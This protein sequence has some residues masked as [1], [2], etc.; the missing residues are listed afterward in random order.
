[1][2]RRMGDWRFGALGAPRGGT[3]GFASRGVTSARRPRLASR[4]PLCAAALALCAGLGGT[5]AGQEH[6]RQPVEFFDGFL[7]TEGINA[8]NYRYSRGNNQ[9]SITPDTSTFFA[10]DY[11]LAYANFNRASDSRYW[12]NVSVRFESRQSDTLANPGQPGM[13]TIFQL[14]WSTALVSFFVSTGDRGVSRVYTTTTATPQLDGR[15]IRWPEHDNWLRLNAVNGNNFDIDLAILAVVPTSVSIQRRAEDGLSESELAGNTYRAGQLI[16]FVVGMS[17]NVTRGREA[18]L[19]GETG[20]RGAGLYFRIGDGE[21]M[22]AWDFDRSSGTTIEFTYR[23]QEGDHGELSLIEEEGDTRFLR[24]SFG[25]TDAGGDPIYGDLGVASNLVSG[26]YRVDTV[27][28]VVEEATV[29]GSKLVLTFS[30]ALHE[31]HVPAASAFRLWRSLGTS[32]S[33]D[34]VA[35]DGRKVT[36]AL[37]EAS[38]VNE[39]WSVRYTPPADDALRD[40]AGNRAAYFRVDVT[41]ERE[42]HHL[43]FAELKSLSP[44][45]AGATT[46]YKASFPGD[47]EV[48]TVEVRHSPLV[49][50]AIAP[51]DADAGTPGHQFRLPERGRAAATLTVTATSEAAG[52]TITYTVE[53]V[54]RFGLSI[55]VP[56]ESGGVLR[57]DE[58]G[59]LPIQIRSDRPG[60]ELH[61]YRARLALLPVAN[62]GANHDHY[63]LSPA[64]GVLDFAVGD[65]QT[66]TVTL[67]AADDAYDNPDRRFDLRLIDPNVVG[68]EQFITSAFGGGTQSVV[69]AD[70]DA[71][72]GVTTTLNDDGSVTLAWPVGEGEGTDF[73]Y[74]FKVDRDTD[75]VGW[76]DPVS[77]DATGGGSATVDPAAAGLCMGER[78]VFE[79]WRPG[80]PPETVYA[81]PRQA[82][83]PVVS[84]TAMQDAYVPYQGSELDLSDSATAKWTLRR[85]GDARLRL[86]HVRLRYR[87]RDAS[88]EDTANAGFFAGDSTRVIKHPPW[89]GDGRVFCAMT[90]EVV[91]ADHYD[92]DPVRYRGTVQVK[93]PGAVCDEY[94]E[95]TMT[96]GEGAFSATR[97]YS[98]STNPD[99]YGSI[100]PGTFAQGGNTYTV[101]AVAHDGTGNTVSV[102]LDRRLDFALRIGAMRVSGLR[103]SSLSGGTLHRYTA[104]PPRDPGWRVGDTV[105]VELFPAPIAP[106]EGQRAE[107]AEP[108]RV[109]LESSPAGHDGRSPVTVRIAFSEPVAITEAAMRAHALRVLDGTVTGA[110]RVD[111]RPGVWDIELTPA[112]RADVAL[113]VPYTASCDAEGAICTADARP[114]EVGIALYVQRLPL[115]VAAET[116]HGHDAESAFAVRLRFSEPVATAAAELRAALSVAG[117]T[118]EAFAAV[119]GRGDLFEATLVPGG[120]GDVTLSLPPS[121]PSCAEPR[122]VCTADGSPL[123]NGVRATVGRARLTARFESAPGPHAGPSDPFSLR[124]RFSE[125]LAAGTN[126]HAALAVEGGALDGVA[127]LDGRA[128]LWSVGVTPESDADVVV[129]L[130]A[131]VSCDA[132]GAVCTADARALAQAAA[133][134]V[135][136]PGPITVR[137]LEEPETHDGGEFRFKAVF[138]DE[139]ATTRSAMRDAVFAVSGGRVLAAWQVAG[140]EHMWRVRIEPASDGPVRIE[141]PATASCGDSG[142]VCTADGRR[143]AEGVEFEVE[144]PRPGVAT[145]MLTVADARAAPGAPVE[146]VLRLSRA[147]GEAVTVDYAT[148]DGTATA[149]ADYA[150]SSGTVTFASGERSGTVSVATIDDGVA[151]PEETFTLTLSRPGGGAALAD[152]EAIGTI[153]VPAGPTASFD[154][155][156]VPAG[157]A[158]TAF[159]V[160]LAF[161]EEIEGIGYAWVRDTLMS[162]TGATVANAR[163]LEAGSNV[164]WELDVE[165]DAWGADVTLALAAGTALPGGAA[166][167]AGDAVSVPGQRALSVADATAAEGT[168]ASFAVTL[169]RAAPGTVTVDYATADGT[170]TAGEDYAAASGTLTFAPG[171]TGKTVRVATAHDE[172]DDDG[173]TFSLTLSGPGGNAR[174]AGA[175]ATGTIEEAAAEVTAAAVTATPGDNGTWDE[176]ETVEAE[177]RFSAPVTVTAPEGAVP[178]LA[179]L[180]DGARREAA[181]T[182]GSGTDRLTFAFEVT[183][184]DAGARKARVA[185]DGLSLDGASLAAAGGGAVDTRYAVAPWVTAVALL[186]DDSGDN[187]WTPGETVEVRLTFSEPVTVEGGPPRVIF[188]VAGAPVRP[189]YASGSGT[190]TL[191]FAVTLP[192]ANPPLAQIAVIANSLHLN[193]ATIVA[194]GSGLAA[195]LAHEGTAPTPPPGVEEGASLT[196]ELL[197][198]PEAHGGRAFTVDLRFSE[199]VPGLSYATLRDH[200][201]T[202]SGGTV[203][204]AR[205]LDADGAERDRA[206][207]IAI[208]PAAN[209]GDVTVTLPATSDCTAAG[210]VCADGRPLSAAVSVTVPREAAVQPE[211]ATP[212]T[213]R[214]DRVPDE[215]DGSTP[216]VF[217]VLFNKEPAAGYSYATMRDATVRA[218]RDGASVAVRAARRLSEGQNDR[219]EIT[220]APAGKEDVTVSVGPFASCA[221]AGAVCT[222]DGE[223]L[224]NAAAATVLGPPGLAVADARVHE[225]PG[226]TLDFAVTMGRASSA[227]VTVDYATADGTASA[228]EDYT[229]TSGTLTFAAGETAKTVSVPV[230][231]DDHDEGEETLTLSLSNPSGGN[232]WL[233]DATATGTIENS[234]AMP[235]AWLAR[236]GRTVAEQVL[237]A[238]EGRFAASREAGAAVSLAG[239]ALGAAASAEALEALEERE[240]LEAVSKWLEGEERADGDASGSRALTGRDFLTGTSFS[241]TG[242]TAQTG[243]G[244]LWGRGALSSFDGREGAL[245]L[246]GEV[247]SVML[248]ADYAR[249]RATVGLMVTHARGAGEYRSPESG[250][251]V[252][253][254]LTGLYPYGRYEAGRRVELWAVAGYGAG[255]LVLTPEGQGPMTTDTELMLG[256]VGLRGVALAAPAGG[257]VELA[258]KSDALA[259]RT[260]SERTR[261]LAAARGDVTR[262]RLALEGSWRGVTI[263]TGALVPTAEI[264]VRHDGGDAE[265][266]FGLDLGGGL[267]WSD[268]ESGVSAAVRGRGL[269]TH[270][271]RGFRDRGVAGSL[272]FD[273]RPGSERGFSLTLTQTMGGRATG[274]AHALLGQ[275]HLGGLGANEDGDELERRT[276][277][278]E[279][280][281]GFAVFGDRFTARPH[282][283][284]GL[285]HGR[286]EYALGWRLGLAR[287]GPVSM[288]LGLQATRREAVN[289]DAAEPAHALMLRGAVRW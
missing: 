260:T 286:R 170:A 26:R 103:H 67:T 179:V 89:E 33:V 186:P 107:A 62:T 203:I 240:R 69:I 283:G 156:T 247:Q 158:G 111:G 226:A 157:H 83:A 104:A 234:D 280:G 139:V 183:A 9:G 91:D 281:Y 210:A 143:L 106:G 88:W 148:A 25:W 149:G 34:E 253:S 116:P 96:V 51:A 53:V 184:H 159:R 187:V 225:T 263:G 112:S 39:A 18:E 254:R 251:E 215:H 76:S 188:T 132:A 129:T 4:L 23:V 86:C 214:L 6:G 128:D 271:S 108:L 13:W 102:V 277:A 58:G 177:L 257:G 230:L 131:T 100:S 48:A 282:A 196:A 178:T 64:E 279:M 68:P 54:R 130:A 133:V 221:D 93:G 31:D 46:S 37:D 121:P 255:E 268:P 38:T 193:G 228:G 110:A 167:A 269:L 122:A 266:G 61:A 70:D 232:A 258:V 259:V 117:G 78:Y 163:R 216:I 285:S 151:E 175:S 99:P 43:G 152:A 162:A 171:E 284:L 125:A 105:A 270:E 208:A 22:A 14:P 146:F 276:L 24:S 250:G 147:W 168:E 189:N 60:G 242:G 256:A 154:P 79:V 245:S 138:S 28:P 213:V 56:A 35:V 85:T 218:R 21:R 10:R 30:E 278:L 135:P 126:L 201:F 224:S 153:E 180:L 119:D 209:A 264:G 182:G 161:S 66:K 241:L 233:K 97:G 3:G 181:W 44:A 15:E 98:H 72:Y 87:E 32:R 272:A 262:L 90:A 144:G 173:E 249:E 36:L 166:L 115:T 222:E 20:V 165:P 17:G 174:L 274:G 7:T 134:R 192:G 8:T 42:L 5:A 289:D 59:T 199:D 41:D 73:R 229:A 246:N 217:R 52:S 145:P 114:L 124:L 57:V 160:R 248:G 194:V 1:M 200:A 244:S 164:G 27:A 198:V 288:A 136:G 47:I 81:T 49:E 207:E 109:S 94:Y 11:R 205:R 50:V 19:P 75:L 95:G 227:T 235:R 74:R 55:S 120:E 142:A 113:V 287:G 275:R 273:P 140:H 40:T 238:V 63:A 231:G 92:V 65:T 243:Y 239:Q 45:F 212:F 237:E 191:A 118:L 12:R 197:E 265:T 211:P 123:Q 172:A 202:V 190:A 195:E 219:W 82:P 267:S 77:V 252:E 236:F 223:V 204:G 29:A 261:G 101:Y 127:A 137:I 169:D 150:A 206:W 16:R 176:G 185:S 80:E 155:G 71:H 220:V 141:L 2:T 84:V